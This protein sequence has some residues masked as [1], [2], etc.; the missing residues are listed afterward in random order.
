MDS[1]EPKPLQASLRKRF[2]EA[3]VFLYCLRNTFHKSRSTDPVELDIAIERNSGETFKCFVNKVGQIC[4][5]TR[6][7]GGGTITSCMILQPG[8][9]EYRLA[10]NN[11]S[12]DEWIVVEEYLNGVLNI[13]G[14]AS[15]ETIRAANTQSDTFRTILR[16]VV[17]FTRPRMEWYTK[18]IAKNLEYCI[19]EADAE[20][21]SNDEARTAARDLRSLT[22]L[23]EFVA[24]QVVVAEESFATKTEALLH[25]INGS[26]RHSLEGF[27]RAKASGNRGGPADTPWSTMHHAIGRLLSLF[28]GVKVL[29]YARRFWPEAFVDFRVTHVAS[30]IPDDEPP[31][32]R[33]TAGGML[34]RM[35]AEPAVVRA[36]QARADSLR[37][38]KLDDQIKRRC[39]SRRF[40]PIVHAEILNH[41]SVVREDR[42]NA[43]AGE[44]PVRFFREAEFGRYIGCSKP[45]CRLCE[46]Y[47]SA[48]P[49][50]QVR[51]SHQNFYDNWRLPDVYPGEEQL[52]QKR[53]A[54]LEQMVK[55]TRTEVFT[56]LTKGRAVRNQ[57]DS[58]DT[59]TN[60]LLTTDRSSSVIATAGFDDVVSRMSSMSMAASRRPPVESSR[61]S[62]PRSEGDLTLWEE[63]DGGAAI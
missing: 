36:Y 19:E 5:S 10:S 59:P 61:E 26:Y 49:D 51:P 16:R 46:Q 50:I 14:E 45:T 11:R 62:T 55:T 4:D 22:P 44:D 43:M 17:I 39:S 57:F 18:E 34:K 53:D 32:I 30:S 21:T 23:V 27:I 48:Y 24:Q 3:V 58:N 13:L 54:I 20:A 29:I 6:G 37:E 35:S 42:E 38:W 2:Y 33:K 9:V 56:A 40:C 41:N 1:R 25:V 47:F 15:D 63:S 28:L 31:S 60:P 7:N 8:S 12:E 52:E